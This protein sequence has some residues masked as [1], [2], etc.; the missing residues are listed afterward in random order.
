MSNFRKTIGMGIF[1]LTTINFLIFTG[2]NTQKTVVPSDKTFTLVI[3][4]Q[5]FN[6]I[7]IEK[8]TFPEIKKIYGDEYTKITHGTYSVEITYEKLGLA[9]FYCQSD[10]TETIFTIVISEPFLAKTDKG[11]YLNYSSMTDVIKLYG[12]ANWT[13]SNGSKIWSNDYEGISFHVEKDSKLPE[14]PMN[15]KVHEKK[16][17]IQFKIT[18]G[19]Q[20]Q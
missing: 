7:Q 17:V 18:N 10:K 3:P 15:E 5:G 20:C 16:T 9:F 19:F 13:T 14:Y 1:F 8:T 12:K 6:N 11:I 4:G 2:C